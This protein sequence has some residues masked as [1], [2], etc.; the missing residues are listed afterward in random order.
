MTPGSS[1]DEQALS[2]STG[3]GRATTLHQTAEP[4]LSPACSEPT[5]PYRYGAW[6]EERRSLAR[7]CHRHALRVE[8]S[9]S[10]SSAVVKPRTTLRLLA[11]AAGAPV[12]TDRIAAVL[13][14]DDAQP[15]DPAAQVA[16]IDQQAAP[17]A[18]SRASASQMTAA[19]HSRSDWLDLT[20]AAELVAEAELDALLSAMQAAALSSGA[21]CEEVAGGLAFRMTDVWQEHERLAVGRLAARS[22][23]L[24]LAR[25]AAGRR[26]RH[27]SRGCRSSCS[28]STRTTRRPFAWRWQV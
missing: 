12:S 23:R 7:T 16:V 27:G 20:A 26:P 28:R 2:S 21:R 9:T 11:I 4:H 13:W 24:A 8:G 3:T 17:G 10:T 22:E 19:T 18:R 1:G 14:G 6:A 5:T 25:S 15:R